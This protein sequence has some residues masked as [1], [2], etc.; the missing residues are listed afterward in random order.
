MSPK[1]SIYV[2]SVEFLKAIFKFVNLMLQ[3]KQK[4]LYLIGVFPDRPDDLCLLHMSA[5]LIVY[6]TH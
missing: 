2:F 5:Y 1:M 4:T 3:E 6:S